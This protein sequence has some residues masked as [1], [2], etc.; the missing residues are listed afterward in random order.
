MHRRAK[1]AFVLTQR[2]SRS[3]P[4]A[5]TLSDLSEWALKPQQLQGTMASLRNS[6]FEPRKV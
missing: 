2:I 4:M 5:W 3:G 6:V 1:L